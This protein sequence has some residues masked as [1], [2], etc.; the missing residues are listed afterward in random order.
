MNLFA[1][2]KQQWNYNQKEFN[3]SYVRMCVYVYVWLQNATG[4]T[5][6]IKSVNKKDSLLYVNYAPTDKIKY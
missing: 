2:S 4:Q 3:I 1:D 5:D 6:N